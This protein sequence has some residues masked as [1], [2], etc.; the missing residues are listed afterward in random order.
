MI[1]PKNVAGLFSLGAPRVEIYMNSLRE[2]LGKRINKIT[3]FIFQKNQ[4]TPTPAM[5]Q[6]KISCPP[7]L[8]R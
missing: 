3:G 6:R 5:S 7:I 4:V 2:A 8:M 1:V